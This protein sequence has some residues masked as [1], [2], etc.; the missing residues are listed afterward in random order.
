M[1][2]P[3]VHVFVWE[4]EIFGELHAV[5]SIALRRTSARK[6]E[7]YLSPVLL[8]NRNTTS[9]M[10][11]FQ[12]VMNHLLNEVLVNGLAN[13]KLFQRFAIRSN[14][15]FAELGKKSA[16]GQTEITAKT[17]EFVRTFREEMKKGLDELQK[18]QSSPRR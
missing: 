11:F 5:T 12:R 8:D 16:E 17:S 6:N 7:F 4:V 1:S 2:Q 9:K 3:D 10:S 18:Q 14:A 15:I 13:S